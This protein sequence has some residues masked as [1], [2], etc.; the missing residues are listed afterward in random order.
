MAGF[1]GFSGARRFAEAFC[2]LYHKGVGRPGLP[3]RLMVGLH[4]IKHMDE[5][6]RQPAL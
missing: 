5:L 1:L 6:A 4:L 2:T 3:I